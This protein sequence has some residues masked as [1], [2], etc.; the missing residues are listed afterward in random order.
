MDVA[1]GSMEFLPNI[2][3]V[4]VRGL[5]SETLILR[6]DLRGFGVSGGSACSSHS[7]APATCCMRSAST[8]TV[9]TGR[10]AS[11]WDAARPR[12]TSTPSS[13]PS[14]ACWIGADMEL[15]TTHAHTSFCGHG[16]GTVE[17][18]AA[19]AEAAG[20]TTLAVTEHYPL[21]K[22][23]DPRDYLS[24]PAAR[25]GRV[26]GSHRRG[27]RAAPGTRDHRGLRARLA[28]G[29]RRPHDRARTTSPRSSSCWARFTSWTPGPST[30]LRSAAAGTSRA[31]RTPSGAATSSCGAMPCPSDAPFHVMSHPDLA[32]KFAYYPTYD[33]APLYEQAAEACAAAGRMVEVNTSGSYYA[34]KE[35]FP[36]RGAPAPVLPRGRAVHRGHRRAPSRAR[37]ARRGGGLPPHAQCGYRTVTVPTATGDRR[38]IDLIL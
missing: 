23:F 14:P 32:K 27:A 6:F 4:L 15:V 7:L 20:V 25:V 10:C 5:E 31:R 30:T 11:R 29:R 12:R 9:R 21:S 34:C 18:L 35:M 22:A 13:A 38:E 24:M 26:P 3:H 1:P 17:E 19:A 37:G 2:V 8:T 28:R 16:E 36:A 33:A